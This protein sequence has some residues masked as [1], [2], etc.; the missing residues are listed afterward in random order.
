VLERADGSYYTGI[1][2][3]PRRRFEQHRSGKG[4]ARANKV[5]AVVRILCL[6]PGGEYP[7]RCAA[8]P[9][10]RGWIRRQ[11]ALRGGP[12]QPGL[13]GPEGGLA[14]SE[15]GGEEEDQ[16]KEEGRQRKAILKG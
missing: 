16:E 14:A 3:D 7:W 12:G 6:E 13:A 1:S 10:S 15:A 5:S 11:A 2:T 9:R 4:G 8:R